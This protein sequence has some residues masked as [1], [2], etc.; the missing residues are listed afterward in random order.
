MSGKVAHQQNKEASTCRCHFC[1]RGNTDESAETRGRVS[2]AGP[3]GM[4]QLPQQSASVCAEIT[5]IKFSHTPAEG[6]RLTLPYGR[7]GK[8]GSRRFP[9][10]SVR[11]EIDSL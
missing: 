6:W 1:G 5:F 11:P 7:G 3:T 10:G 4:G 8:N 2:V 9:V